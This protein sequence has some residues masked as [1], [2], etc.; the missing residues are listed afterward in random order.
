MEVAEV[1]V[2]IFWPDLGFK[3]EPPIALDYQQ[4]LH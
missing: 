4:K 1:C 2:G 3:R